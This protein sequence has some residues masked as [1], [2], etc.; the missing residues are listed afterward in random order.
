MD[1]KLKKKPK[2]ISKFKD[3]IEFVEDRPGHDMRYFLNT[4]KIKR[5]LNWR[6]KYNIKNGLEN[7]IDWYLKNI[8]KW[9][10]I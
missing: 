8:N 1:K 6:P 3:L 5:K 4:I 10:K 9:R 7:T 2:K